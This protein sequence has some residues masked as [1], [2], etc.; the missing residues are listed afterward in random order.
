M[1]KQLILVIGASSDIGLNLIRNINEDAIIIAHYNSSVDEL[2]KVSK[3]IKNKLVLIKA[4]LA[5]EEQVYEMLSEIERNYGIPSKIVHLAATKFK[6]LRFKDL[7]WFDFQEEIDVSLK[8]FTIILNRF[9]PKL[10]KIRQGKVVCMLSS[11]TINLP[12][13]ALVHYTTI[14][15]ALLGLVKSLASEYGNKNIQINALSPSMIETKFLKNINK[16][17]IEISAHN[18]PLRR[19]ANVDDVVPSILMLLSKDSDYIN[20]VNIPIDGG[21]N[22]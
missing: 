4:N 17:I 9:L 16:K 7:S 14:K 3:S 6:N 19:N 5:I 8:S 12:P 2:L 1:N 15:Y 11:V 20:G 13:K 18:H 10:V 22:H 21:S